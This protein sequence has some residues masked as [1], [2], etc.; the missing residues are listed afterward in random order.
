M[1]LHLKNHLR[2]QGHIPGIFILNPN[3][4]IGETAYELALI[5]GIAEVDEFID[6][7]RYLPIIK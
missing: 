2:G 1:P 4:S 6:Q 7:L 3:L 5:A